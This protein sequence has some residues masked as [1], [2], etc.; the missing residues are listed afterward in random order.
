MTLE[1]IPDWEELGDLPV[2]Y[3]ISG[4]NSEYD[5]DG[6]TNKSD[7]DCTDPPF[8]RAPAPGSS[9]A[10]GFGSGSGSGQMPA[11]SYQ[12]EPGLLCISLKMYL[13]LNGRK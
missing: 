11:I 13:S 6:S 4:S 1:H 10:S 5:S 3:E 12:V 2:Y 9:S 7:F 8:G